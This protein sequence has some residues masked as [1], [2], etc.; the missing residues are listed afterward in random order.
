MSTPKPYRAV[1]SDHYGP[2]D[3]LELAEIETP[4]VGPGEVLVRVEA[5]AISPGDRALVT[6]LPY[7]NRLAGNGIRR[8]KS[9]TPGFDLAGTVERVG[10]AVTRFSAG[11][12][13]FGNA[14]GA[15]AEVAVTDASQLAPIPEGWTF[16]EA[17]AV[18]ESGC[19]AL[20]VVRDRAAIG[21]GDSV[22]VL[23]AGGGVGTYVT[24]LAVARQARVTAVCS[25]TMADEVAALGVDEVVDYRD[26]DL[27][28]LDRRFDVIIDTAGK[29]PLRRLAQ[30]LAPSGQLVVIGADHSRRV[31]GGLGRWLRALALSVVTRRRLR[32]FIASPLSAELLA[33]LVEAMASGAL[34]PAVDRTFPMGDTA[35]AFQYLD[36]RTRPGKVVIV[37]RPDTGPEGD[38]TNRRTA[39]GGDLP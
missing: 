1:V 14:T 39:N 12:A 15:I 5:A 10:G 35:A 9:A 17:A 21:P 34:R 23:G 6:G 28:D 20:Q 27:A 38:P 31:T 4:P 25:A 30:A 16:E 36:H 8:P 24:Q 3:R 13:V 32:P 19:V 33:D 7:I 2:V 22:A 11:Q 26:R 18:P 29:A 37:V